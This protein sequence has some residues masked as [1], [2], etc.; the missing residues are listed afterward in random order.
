MICQVTVY[1]LSGDGD[2]NKKNMTISFLTVGFLS[3]DMKTK[4][5]HHVF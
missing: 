5:A 4:V 3:L 1:V 2:V